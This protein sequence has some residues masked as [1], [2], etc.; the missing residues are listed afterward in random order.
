MGKSVEREDASD[1][2]NEGE[3]ELPDALQ[4]TLVHLL[5]DAAAR[6]E[7]ETARDLDML[8]LSPRQLRVLVT[9]VEQ[10][11][12]SQRPLG[13]LLGIDRTTMV[14]LIDALEKLDLVERKRDPDD[15]R[16]WLVTPTDRGKSTADWAIKMV[17]SAEARALQA[18]TDHQRETLRKL[19]LK[20]SQ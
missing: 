2:A 20:L 16:A 1:G 14:A 18:L 11:P 3:L 5:T 8:G 9:L 12:A 13:D 17:Q 7:K 19:L 4:N 10:G 6:I 15:R